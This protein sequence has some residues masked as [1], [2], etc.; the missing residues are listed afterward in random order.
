MT[1]LTIH[2]VVKNHQE[3]IA[4]TLESLLPLK[5]RIVI[6][7]IGSSDATPDICKRYGIGVIRLSLN[8]DYSQ[9]KNSLSSEGWTM[10]VEPWETL[11]RGHEAILSAVRE[12]K[13]Y[14]FHVLQEGVVTKQVRLWHSSLGLKFVN[15][16]Y[17]T[18]VAD[19][20]DLPVYL[21]SA[22]TNVPE[23]KLIERWI[24]KCPL[25]TE[26]LYYR[27]CGLLVRKQWEEAIKAANH[28][29]FQEKKPKMSLTM[30]RYYCSMVSC[31]VKKDFQAAVNYLLPCLA[32]RPTMAEFW[33]LLG[34]IYYAGK[35]FHKAKEFYHNALVLGTRRLKDSWPLE[36]SK[37][38]EY[39]TKM[40]AACQSVNESIK[41]Y[42]GLK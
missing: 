35:L 38:K 26:P 9:V 10:W 3:T 22:G 4:S 11:L 14:N 40:M 21:H 31:Y 32:E 12:V 15:P 19:A 33:C 41:G 39:P 23:M 42:V 5:S 17:E 13:P 37:Y 1:K 29:I 25:A 24:E 27:A 36:I 20:S 18:V 8:E 2:L 28:Y 16:V 6:A 30:T 7:D 34:D